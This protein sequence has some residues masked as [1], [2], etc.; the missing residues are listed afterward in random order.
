MAGLRPGKRPAGPAAP[1]KP[2]KPAAKSKSKTGNAECSAAAST[3]Q[4]AIRS[5]GTAG[6]EVY[7]TLGKCRAMVN[8]KKR[9]EAY[10]RTGKY[11]DQGAKAAESR[12]QGRFDS[13]LITKKS[14]TAK[15]KELL[16]TRAAKNAPKPAAAPAA[17]KPEPAGGTLAPGRG[18]PERKA[19]AEFLKA[20]RKNDAI[21]AANVAHNAAAKRG[22]GSSVYTDGTGLIMMKGGKVLREESLADIKQAKINQ[23][24]EKLRKIGSAKIASVATTKPAAKP[25][26]KPPESAKPYS[27]NGK[28][29]PGRGTDFRKEQAKYLIEDRKNSQAARKALSEATRDRELPWMVNGVEITGDPNHRPQVPAPVARFTAARNEKAATLRQERFER[30]GK[31]YELKPTKKTRKKSSATAK[32]APLKP[33]Q[34]ADSVLVHRGN[35]WRDGGEAIPPRPAAA[36][37]APRPAEKRYS[38]ERKLAPGRGTEERNEIAYQLKRIRKPVTIHVMAEKAFSPTE[39]VDK[40]ESTG[41]GSGIMVP[42]RFDHNA[43]REKVSRQMGLDK[44]LA[45]NRRKAKASTRK[46]NKL[47]KTDAATNPAPAAA[48]AAP[49][50]ALAP[51]RG[52]EAR[53]DL[54]AYKASYVRGNPVYG[55]IVTRNHVKRKLAEK[56]AADRQ[57]RDPNPQGSLFETGPTRL[58]RLVAR[59]RVDRASS[60]RGLPRSQKP[61][62]GAMYG[63]ALSRGS[64][65]VRPP[66]TNEQLRNMVKPGPKLAAGRGTAE[67]NQAAGMLRGLRAQG[68]PGRAIARAVREGAVASGPSGINLTNP[69]R[70]RLSLKPSQVAARINM[71]AEDMHGDARR[72]Y[73]MATSDASRLL[74]KS[75]NI[76]EQQLKKDRSFQLAAKQSSPREALIRKAQLIRE[77]AASSLGM[78]RRFVRA[79]VQRSTFIGSPGAQKRS[80][81]N[82]L[83]K[84][85][86]A[87]RE[88]G[89]KR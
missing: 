72:N 29:A 58:E 50:P 25:K 85:R 40:Y 4:K 10:G 27:L 78:A 88:Y 57:G 20:V 32:P 49:R 44:A 18:T 76:S 73:A 9:I 37:A 67:R 87:A 81:G 59:L 35:E 82:A 77:T 22:D 55:D 19:Q 16:A 89:R 60:G 71:V 21:A 23:I 66:A 47:A 30:L 54:A 63:G 6:P 14:R 7:K 36:T 84:L 64:E 68:K 31:G 8:E 24:R 65:Q 33:A 17:A 34:F 80:T 51:G 38:F 45:R 3:W 53:K 39:Y 75:G 52:T 62:P 74:T 15:A 61:I 42:K 11:S 43:A 12:L 26:A 79:G 83:N 46:A 86:A 2:G 69:D 56:Y 1:K 5:G 28:L 41:G 70:K 13:N 48:T